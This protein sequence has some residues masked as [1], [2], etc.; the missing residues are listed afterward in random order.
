MNT[1]QLITSLLAGDPRALARAITYVE[2]EDSRSRD[3]LKEIYPKARPVPILGV[4]GPAGVGKSSLVDQLIAGYRAQNLTVG[5]VAVDPSSPFSGGAILGDRIRMQR[6]GTDP[7]VFIRSMATRG[8]LGGIAAATF[9][10]TDLLAASGKDIIVIET[11]GVGQDEVDIVKVAHTTLVVL[12]PGLGDEVQAMKA[13]LM[14]IADLL[15]INKSDRPEAEKMEAELQ[16]VLSFFQPADAWRPQ[17]LKTVAT[18]NTGVERLLSA[19]QEHSAYLKSSGKLQSKLREQSRQRMI[20]A[21]EYHVTS[22]IIE[23]GFEKFGIS[24]KIEDI[25]QRRI[26]PHSAVHELLRHFKMES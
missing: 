18:S 11:V 24:Q 1:T 20:D 2:N 8:K 13:G 23:E 19:I 7:G 14:E 9:D 17:I 4:T 5:V 15:V 25:A 3:I 6:H 10:V 21:L 22:R 12:M 26:D 16:A